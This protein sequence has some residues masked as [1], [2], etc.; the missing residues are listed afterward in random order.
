MGTGFLLGDGLVLTAR[1]VVEAALG[2]CEV[3]AL[4]HPA[5][6]SSTL[7]TLGDAD[8]DGALLRVS[9]RLG[10]VGRVRLGRLVGDER[11][12]CETTGFPWAQL[13]RRDDVTIRRSEHLVGEVDRLS[14]QRFGG[15]SSVLTI[16]VHGSVPE[17][18]MTA[19][20]AWEGMSGAGVVCGELL[21]G[22]V[23]AHPAHFATDRLLAVPLTWLIASP[24]LASAL[25]DARGQPV[26]LEAV[27]A[28][29]VL[30]P[31][32][33]QPPPR[34]LRQSS[35]FLLGARYG[36]VPFRP[37]PELERLRVWAHSDQ[38]TDIAVLTG[39]GGVGKTRLSRELCRTA[40]GWIAGALASRPAGDEIA[41]LARADAPLLVVVDDYA[42]AR[43]GQ[44][45]A[46]LEHLVHDRT[47]R[48]PRRL[49]LSARQ[50]GD[51]WTQLQDDCTDSE[52]RDLL[53]SALTIELGAA[54]DTVEG[55]LDAYLSAIAAY[56]PHTGPALS[57]PVVPDLGDRL[58]ETVLFLHMAALSALPGGD[59]GSPSSASI[60]ADLLA[61]TIAREQ[62]YWSRLAGTSDP[63]LRIDRHVQTC[64]MAV[65]TLAA[66]TTTNNPANED[67]TAT[68]LEII[69]D[70]AGDV[71]TRRRVAR[72]LHSL[73]RPR[74]GWIAPLEPDL[75]GEALVAA[76]LDAAP[77][78]ANDLLARADEPTTIRALTVLTR[79]SRHHDVCRTSLGDAIDEHLQRVAS[80][81]IEVA[82]QLGD[83]IGVLLARALES[84]PD[85]AL[86]FAMLRQIPQRTVSLREAAAVAV[87]QALQHDEGHEQVRLLFEHSTRL[88]ALGRHDDALTTITE[89]VRLNRALARMQPDNFAEDLAASLNNQSRCLF[90]LGRRQEALTAIEEAV[91][92]RRALAQVRPDAIPGLAGSLNN[93]SSCLGEMGRHEE[94]LSAIQ[95]GVKIRRALAH[96]HA[97]FLPDLAASLSNESRCL[98]QLG[99][100]KE[101]LAAS[102][103]AV[104]VHREVARARPDAFLP[105]LAGSLSNH[106][107]CLLDFERREEAVSAIVE[108]V[109]IRYSLAQARPDAFL[110]QLL[111]SL[112]NLSTCLGELGRH[113]DALHAVDES[114]RIHRELARSRPDSVVPNLAM[115][116]N[117]Q[118]N[119]LSEVGRFEDALAAV[120]EA[121]DLS[122]TLAAAHPAAFKPHLAMSLHNQSDRLSKLGRSADALA[123][124]D[125]A[126]SVYRALA[127]EEADAFIADLAGSLRHQ[128][129]CL[130]EL[131][132]REDALAAIDEAVHLPLPMLDDVTHLPP[133][134]ASLIDTYLKRCTEAGRQP[135]ADIVH[136]ASASRG[137]DP[138]GTA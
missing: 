124:I 87:T 24:R 55:R 2:P 103:K 10:D 19:G 36:V 123:A 30:Q 80:S 1:H 31:P 32:Y 63:P 50:L 38:D 34:R 61:R 116:L 58:F 70:L 91:Q 121:V 71:A 100:R 98:A 97:E 62:R 95:A 48:Q 138:Q 131:G 111:T 115:V 119:R 92:M 64:A 90:D 85:P 127:I 44:I 68:L 28:Q 74:A 27:E 53:A 52:I 94:A 59:P 101:A 15:A 73:Y 17:G 136:R 11:A 25:S 113:D 96:R 29:A 109:Q 126:V 110:P 4:D 7:A 135:D 35:S 22:V 45:V 114:V 18:R 13:E 88:H 128:S 78:L 117:N 75:L 69:A 112:T 77:D 37:R 130:S 82:Q 106:A 47:S 42:E 129:D 133:G 46:L 49:L 20:S 105:E 67:E 122:R 6:V 26:V 104:D 40:D 132:R 79:A 102:Q 84:H 16:H 39:P 89:A 99:R 83:P 56:A 81:A 3:R 21:V 43:R 108:S 9:G 60:R 93:L 12:R 134:D 41:R 65:A 86:A 51:W 66:S 107:R 8:R 72:W 33:D 125:E 14:G 5:W 57:S 54:D 137:P 23:V 120:E 76:A 118:S